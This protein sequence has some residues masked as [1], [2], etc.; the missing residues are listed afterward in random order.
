[1]KLRKVIGPCAGSS[2]FA[3]LTTALACAAP[4]D[5]NAFSSLGPWPGG[6]FVIDTTDL[7]FNGMAGGIVQ[8]QAGGP[9]VAVFTFDGGTLIAAGDTI[10]VRGSRPGVLLF[11]GSATIQGTID[12]SGRPAGQSRIGAA[13]GPG[14]GD[15]GNGATAGTAE[16]GQPGAGP[17]GGRG[18]G[19]ASG[20]GGFN[21]GGGGGFGGP[22]APGGRGVCCGEGAGGVT[23]GDLR[24][25]L[26][27]GSGG[28]GGGWG[29]GFGPWISGAGGGGGGGGIEIGALELL[30]LVNAKIVADG[31]AGGSSPSS[32][33]GEGGGG[34]GGSGGAVLLHAF[35]LSLNA[36][37]LVSARGGAV[38][39]AGVPGGCGGGG[40]ILL[41][42]NTDGML[43]N[44]AMVDIRPGFGPGV[45]FAGHPCD[46]MTG[47]VGT[48]DIVSDPFVGLVPTSAPV[49]DPAT[50]LLLVSGLVG[51][52]LLRG[53][54]LYKPER[55]NLDTEWV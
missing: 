1:M 27:G 48:F 55:Q 26:Q 12:A 53:R 14:G 11:Q 50:A 5:P 51:L 23:Y 34:G 28:G 9:D 17:G 52:G 39:L 30:S 41:M 10:T 16:T 22:G 44:N 37:T 45:G 47:S 36:G 31:G 13:G 38:V 29:F 25:A 4:L 15:G 24:T 46:P 6:S 19:Q 33:T 43:T 35:S 8:P 3:L 54:R 40:R 32:P 7:T 42:T 2:L 21:G 18:A 20:G 49:P